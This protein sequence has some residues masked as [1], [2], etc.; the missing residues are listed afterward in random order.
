MA[1]MSSICPLGNA[2]SLALD[3][4]IPFD[5]RES[6]GNKHHYAHST[7]GQ[8]HRRRVG[9]AAQIGGAIFLI[10]LLFCTPA[11]ADPFVEL[12][13]AAGFGVLA[14]G[15]ASGRFAI[16]PSASLSVGGKR[17]F[18]VARETISFLGA[19]GGRFGVNNETSVGGGLSWERVNVSGG[20]S[21]AG[22]SLPICGPRLC[23]Q[24]RGLVPGGNVRL[25]VF[26]P[27]LSGGLGVAVDCGF[28]WI[29]GQADAVWTGVSVRC[30]AGPILRFSSRP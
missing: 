23:A 13:G 5:V 20:L 7:E 4:G 12:S 11:L 15:V 18:F 9:S 22:F 6:L 30:S 29:T 8:H 25:D 28:I 3:S 16:S 1:F 26:G 24:M 27:Y 19:T 14:A 17:G 21:L 10:S 2:L